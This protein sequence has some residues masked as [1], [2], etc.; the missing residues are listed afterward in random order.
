MESMKVIEV[1][2][3]YSPDFP[4]LLLPSA[5]PS[6]KVLIELPFPEKY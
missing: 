3:V 1:P 4:K 2:R 6:K 5:L